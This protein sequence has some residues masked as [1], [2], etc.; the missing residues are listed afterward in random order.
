[1]PYRPPDPELQSEYEGLLAVA[2][3]QPTPELQTAA[4]DL[5]LRLRS[6]LI[7]LA[8]WHAEEGPEYRATAAQCRS[9]TRIAGAAAHPFLVREFGSGSIPSAAESR[10]L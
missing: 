3:Q 7:D 9:L 1:M 4:N 5:A 6:R 2:A 8:T 10:T